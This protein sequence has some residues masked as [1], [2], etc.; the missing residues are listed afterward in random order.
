MERKTTYGL[1]TVLLIGGICFGLNSV[2]GLFTPY[3]FW[4]ARQDI[5]NKKI[6]IAFIG[7]MPLNFDQKQKLAKFYGLEFHLIGCRVSSDN[8]NRTK[9]YNNAMIDYLENKY[10][11]GWWTKFQAQLDS[12]DKAK[13]SVVQQSKTTIEL[14]QGLWFHDQDSLATLTIKNNQWSF[15]Y[16]GIQATA[17]DY[18]A[19]S[20]TDKLPEFTKEAEKAK[21]LILTNKS[22]TFKYEI[23]GLTD[24]TFSMM[25]FPT[26]KI[27]LYRKLQ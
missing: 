11:V 26:G 5:S 6:Q 16:K 12:I 8:V 7:E 21:F 17:D 15:N 20:I 19:I 22:D 13:N 4:T 25:Y 24:S 9:Y 18:Y 1:L 10:G 2:F 3:N 27:H 23:L 14:M